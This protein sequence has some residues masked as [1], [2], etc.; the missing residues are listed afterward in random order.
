VPALAVLAKAF[1]ELENP[2]TLIFASNDIMAMAAMDAVR[3]RGLRVPEDISVLGFDDIPQASLVRPALTTV[4][5]P[6]EQMG[7][8][9]TQMLLEIFKNPE[10][11]PK[12][13]ELPTELIIRDSTAKPKDRSG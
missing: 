9:A 5:Q 11:K 8:V 4:R 7:R 10:S 6:L 12:R 13:I 1:L 3:E 2:P